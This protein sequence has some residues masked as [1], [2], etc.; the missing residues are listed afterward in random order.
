[1]IYKTVCGQTKEKQGTELHCTS[2]I[3][4]PP[5]EKTEIQR[6]YSKNNMVY[7]NLYRTHFISQS[8]P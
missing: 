3:P 1:M 4:P 5:I 8:T 7:G 6:L 2:P